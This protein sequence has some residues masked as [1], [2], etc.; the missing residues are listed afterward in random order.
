M[1]WLWTAAAASACPTIVPV[2][3]AEAWQAHVASITVSVGAATVS[4]WRDA[5]HRGPPT[6]TIDDAMQG[7]PGARRIGSAWTFHGVAPTV[8]VYG[9]EVTLR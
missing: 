6:R 5:G 7:V 4:D 9:A 2:Q 1:M 8:F 3:V